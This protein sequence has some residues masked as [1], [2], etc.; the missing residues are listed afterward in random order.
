M[1]TWPGCPCAEQTTL[2]FKENP[3]PTF[4]PSD[5]TSLLSYN[6]SIGV[7]HP[8]GQAPLISWLSDQPR[9]SLSWVLCFD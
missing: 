2:V 6:L 3:R 8:P 9:M 4:L 5:C 7:P 1:V